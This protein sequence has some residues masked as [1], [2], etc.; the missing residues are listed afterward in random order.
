MLRVLLIRH[1]RLPADPDWALLRL[2]P[3][4]GRPYLAAYETPAADGGCR[5]PVPQPGPSTRLPACAN[6]WHFQ[7]LARWLQGL[8]SAEPHGD[9]DFRPSCSIAVS[10][11]CS[12]DVSKK[13]SHNAATLRIP[14]RPLEPRNGRKFQPQ[15][16]AVGNVLVLQVFEL[17]QQLTRTLGGPGVPVRSRD[18][19]LRLPGVGRV[20]DAEWRRCRTAGSSGIGR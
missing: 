7:N 16:V 15:P 20:F 18:A 10:G 8:G 11:P 3:Q 6:A 14:F 2:R 4:P 17:D 13:H 5:R 19:D 9:S 1:R 12:C